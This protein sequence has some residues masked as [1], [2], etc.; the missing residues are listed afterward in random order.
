V[1]KKLL[2]YYFWWAA[3]IAAKPS[4]PCNKRLGHAITKT[5]LTTNTLKFYQINLKAIK[6]T[7]INHINHIEW[8]ARVLAIVL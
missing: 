6:I 1:R 8:K 5:K 3:A 4:N 7:I 2:G